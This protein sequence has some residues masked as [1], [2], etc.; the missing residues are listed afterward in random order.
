MANTAKLNKLREIFRKD[1]SGSF[2]I[3]VINER[4]RIGINSSQ[5]ALADGRCSAFMR[6]NPE[7]RHNTTKIKN[8]IPGVFPQNNRSKQKPRR[9]A[10]GS[11]YF[12]IG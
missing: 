11:K 9:S 3:K 12:F 4:K 5:L 6:K 8:D 7:T 2:L 10:T 1:V